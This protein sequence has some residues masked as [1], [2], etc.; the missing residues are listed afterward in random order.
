M[1]R[2]ISQWWEGSQGRRLE[3][4][5]AAALAVQ[6]AAVVSVSLRYLFESL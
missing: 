5:L 2:R 3:A 6:L 1:R 4:E